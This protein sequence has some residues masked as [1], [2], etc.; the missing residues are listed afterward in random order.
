[1]ITDTCDKVS[2]IRFVDHKTDWRNF[3]VVL[4]P[5]SDGKNNGV[6]AQ[7]C[8]GKFSKNNRETCQVEFFLKYG[9]VLSIL[10]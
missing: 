3:K 7:T 10:F 4:I 2:T 8:S 1:M 6:I 9:P 5:A